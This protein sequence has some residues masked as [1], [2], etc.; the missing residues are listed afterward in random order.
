MKTIAVLAVCLAVGLCTVATP[1]A[2]P[3]AD[4]TVA[5]FEASLYQ[6]SMRML[7]DCGDGCDD[8]GAG[9]TC[10]SHIGKAPCTCTDG[11]WVCF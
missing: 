2:A 4:T 8:P 5:D 6:T 1:A 9:R 3:A 10:V 11:V 7:P